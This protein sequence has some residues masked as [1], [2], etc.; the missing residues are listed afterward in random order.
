MRSKL[1]NHYRYPENAATIM[2]RLH[3]IVYFLNFSAAEING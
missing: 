3:S 2:S 1:P